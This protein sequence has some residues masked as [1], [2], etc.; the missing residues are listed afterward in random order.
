[1]FTSGEFVYNGAILS[2]KL[3]SLETIKYLGI[4]ITYKEIL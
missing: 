2:R 4:T 3:E 1:V